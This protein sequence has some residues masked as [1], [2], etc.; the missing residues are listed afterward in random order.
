MAQQTLA[1]VTIVVPDYDVGLAYFTGVLGFELVEDTDLGNGKRWVLIAPRGSKACRLLLARAT[2]EAQDTAI[3]NQ[4]GGRVAF[5]L[6]T[7]DFDA[8]YAVYTE[9]G[10]DFQ[11]EPREEPYGKVVVF[12]DAFGNLWDFI[13]PKGV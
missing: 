10:V 8:D 2:S 7:D 12:R 11:E 6:Y 5:F 4:T 13:Q 9:A 3:G 1:A